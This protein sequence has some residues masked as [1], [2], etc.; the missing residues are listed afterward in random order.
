LDVE[1]LILPEQVTS[2]AVSQALLEFLTATRALWPFIDVNPN[3]SKEQERDKEADNLV[4]GGEKSYEE[5][6]VGKTRCRN[7]GK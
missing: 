5:L 4:W 6:L 1:I 2:A 7:L 3:L